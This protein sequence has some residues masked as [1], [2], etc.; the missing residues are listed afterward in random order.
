MRR[1]R[2]WSA[3]VSTALPF[4][5]PITPSRSAVAH[6]AADRA[7]QRQSSGR[8]QPDTGV[9]CDGQPGWQAGDL[10]VD[11]GPTRLGLESTIVGFETDCPSCCGPARSPPRRSKRSPARFRFPA[12]PGFQHPDNWRA[13]TRRGRCSELQRDGG[14]FRRGNAGIRRTAADLRG[15]RAQ[16]QSPRRSRRGGGQSVCDAARARCRPPLRHRRDADTGN[17]SRRSDQRPAPA[18]RRAAEILP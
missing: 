4:A 9:A 17:G 15:A 13:I 1:C 10:I 18:R 8:N 3:P 2:C 7:A 14:G 6:R 16:S 11:G 12:V 5:F